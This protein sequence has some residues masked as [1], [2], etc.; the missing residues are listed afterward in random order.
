MADLKKKKRALGQNVNMF[1]RF[2]RSSIYISA[3]ITKKK[4]VELSN[5]EG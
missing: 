2:N 3:S 5:H 1:K 4:K